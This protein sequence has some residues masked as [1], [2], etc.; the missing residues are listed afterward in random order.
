MAV[1]SGTKAHERARRAQ[2]LLGLG[3]L[4]VIAALWSSWHQLQ[5]VQDLARGA[6]VPDA[7]IEASDAR[8]QLFAFV[9]LGLGLVSA[10][11]FLMWTST[12]TKRLI[13]LGVTNMKYAPTWSVLGFLIPILNLFRPYQ[14]MSELW[15]ASEVVPGPDDPWVKRQ[16]PMIVGVWF[17]ILIVESIVGRL[18]SR[19]S[20]DTIEQVMQT[21]WLTVLSDALG[22]FTALA[23]LRLVAETDAR[24]RI[25][26]MRLAQAPAPAAAVPAV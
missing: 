8:Q 20:F 5:L 4:L 22:A 18:V 13:E 9:Q 26:E 2:W 6:N 21:A 16:A 11:A 14:V 19:A 24:L 12:L 7:E 17:A 10:V 1:V 15:R 25:S 23:A 3:A